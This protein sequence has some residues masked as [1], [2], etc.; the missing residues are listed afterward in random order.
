[1]NNPGK[2]RYKKKGNKFAGMVMFLLIFLLS[3][4]TIITIQIRAQR[5]NQQIDKTAA[6]TSSQDVIEQKITVDKTNTDEYIKEIVGPIDEPITE[7]IIEAKNTQSVFV[8]PV[9]GNVIKAYSPDSLLYSNTMG[10]WR[11]HMGTDII[12]E[13][14]SEI[15]S[16]GEGVVSNIYN[17]GELGT[18]VVINH[19]NDIITKYCNVSVHG[20]ITIGT[21]V[22]AGEVIGLV[23]NNPPSE[24]E[25]EL[26]IHI[27]AAKGSVRINPM[28]LIK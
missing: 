6:S 23:I 15:S 8:M 7:N 19:N 5:R 1:M 21:K 12:C 4:S 9:K 13:Y 3:V 28:S 22:K 27:E 26:H 2:I 16:M 25:D 14:E 18:T 11:Q 10:D 24:I 20:N 17:D